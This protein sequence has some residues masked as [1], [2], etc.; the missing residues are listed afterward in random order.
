MVIGYL[1]IPD[2]YWVNNA[3]FNEK[4]EYVMEEKEL[5]NIYI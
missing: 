1:D 4:Y 5:S 3:T 2:E